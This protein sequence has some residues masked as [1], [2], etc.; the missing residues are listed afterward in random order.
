[1]N[2]IFKKYYFKIV[3]IDEKEANQQFD[4]NNIEVIPNSDNNLIDNNN[5]EVIPNHVNNNK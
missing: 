4:N 3:F 1:M 5:N 2:K